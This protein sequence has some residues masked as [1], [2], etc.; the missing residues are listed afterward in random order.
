[1]MTEMADGWVEV[2]AV[3]DPTVWTRFE[4]NPSPT[5]RD[6]RVRVELQRSNISGTHLAPLFHCQS[7]S[8]RL[9]VLPDAS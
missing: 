8:T 4:K 9:E 6:K 3:R 2:A 1:M 5:E 7:A